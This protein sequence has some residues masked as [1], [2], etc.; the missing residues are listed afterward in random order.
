MGG[1]NAGQGVN[2]K[3]CSKGEVSDPV[4]SQLMSFAVQDAK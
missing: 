3:A 1:E 2:G 4:P